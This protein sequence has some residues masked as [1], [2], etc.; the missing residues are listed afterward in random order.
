MD[1]VA[2]AEIRELGVRATD[3][4][5]FP[6]WTLCFDRDSGLLCSS[7]NRFRPISSP[8]T[9]PVSQTVR[10]RYSRGILECL[11]T[12][13]AKVALASALIVEHF[14][15]VEDVCSCERAC[16]VDLSSDP[17]LLE[18]AEEQFSN[19]TGRRDEPRSADR[20]DS[21]NG[22]GL[23]HEHRSGLQTDRNCLQHGLDPRL[24]RAP[25]SSRYAPSGNIPG[26]RLEAVV[27]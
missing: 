10:G 11:G 9:S 4:L 5:W 24:P 25:E 17:L 16:S 13:A 2:I 8:W 27:L 23:P 7:V 1:A 6:G 15:R 26:P 3:K 20:A 18:A 12:N 19:R 21:T 22:G 14:H